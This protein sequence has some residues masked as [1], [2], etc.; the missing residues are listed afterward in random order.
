MIEIKAPKKP[1]NMRNISECAGPN[2]QVRVHGLS[3]HSKVLASLPPT[4]DRDKRQDL[5]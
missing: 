3:L 4:Q 2:A 1:K 5:M